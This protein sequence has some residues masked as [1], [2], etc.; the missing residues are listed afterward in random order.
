MNKRSAESLGK[1]IESAKN[2]SDE[3]IAAHDVAGAI[4]CVE[5][6]FDEIAADNLI[7]FFH[8][9]LSSGD[10]FGS[11]RNLS[12]NERNLLDYIGVVFGRYV[13]GKVLDVAFGIKKPR[14]RK[15]DPSLPM[16]DLA[17]AASVE[18][19]VRKSSQPKMEP[20]CIDIAKAFNL[21][22]KTVEKIYN[23][24]KSAVGSLDNSALAL[25]AQHLAK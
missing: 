4:A 8:S 15:S 12:E 13:D 23:D 10:I 14:G 22:W 3:A 1:A 9:A 21:G 18:I 7:R 25:L 17:I 5:H 19:A 11:R 6:D 24:F 20:I 16:R 2:A